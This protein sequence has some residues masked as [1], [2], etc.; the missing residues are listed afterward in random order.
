[1]KH[2]PQN[3]LFSRRLGFFCL[4][5]IISNVAHV[6]GY[7]RFLVSTLSCSKPLALD[8]TI[9]MVGKSG[10]PAVGISVEVYSNTRSISLTNGGSYTS[11]ELLKVDLSF[12]PT[13]SQ[14]QVEG[15]G[16]LFQVSGAVFE[17]SQG[18]NGCSNFF[19]T[20]KKSPTIVMPSNGA[21]V[22][23]KA[24][25]VTDSSSGGRQVYITETL[26]LS[27]ADVIPNPSLLTTVAPTKPTTVTKVDMAMN[28]VLPNVAQSSITGNSNSNGQ[29]KSAM[30][31]VLSKIAP[32]ESISVNILTSAP[33]STC[34]TFDVTY[35]GYLVDL[36]CWNM[37]DHIAVDGANLV[38]EP[39]KHTVGCM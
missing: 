28:L 21:T 31:S 34:V 26:L 1:M 11:G 4:W 36:F 16:W 2:Q 38:T 14:T 8:G 7:S 6:C 22:T 12:Y 23:F 18:G 17:S 3:L 27:S 33:T 9:Y 19:R 25:Y 30:L 10:K 24:G 35:T 15:Q 13:D 5:S 29:V 39:E 20:T 32:F 37:T